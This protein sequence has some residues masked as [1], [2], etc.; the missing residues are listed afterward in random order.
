M[1]LCDDMKCEVACDAF[2]KL[3]AAECE[4]SADINR[5]ASA[6]EVS[7]SERLLPD[8]IPMLLHQTH[9]VPAICGRVSAL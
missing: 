6:E 7:Q 5:K 1:T 9:D 8:T 3:W 4:K 2:E